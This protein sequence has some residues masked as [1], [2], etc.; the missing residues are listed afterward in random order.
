MESALN[1]VSRRLASRHARFAAIVSPLALALAGQAAAQTAE[2][3][4]AGQGAENS[5]N[6]PEIVVTAQF[7]KQRLQDT[8]LAI[9]AVNSAIMEAKHQVTISDIANSTPSL[10]IAP[11]SNGGGPAIPVLTLRGMGQSDSVGGVEPGVGVYVDDVYY[12]I[13]NGSIFELMDLDRVE[14]LR[15]PQGTLSGKNSEGGSVKLYSKE[16]SNTPEGAIEASYGSY[17]R[18]QL[19]GA[20]NIPLVDNRIM[21]RV[22]GV[23]RHERGYIKRLDYACVNPNSS[24]PIVDPA[25]VNHGCV[26]GTAGGQDL[27]AVRATLR[28]VPATG[29]EDTITVD[30]TSDH[31]GLDPA[32]L[33]F[34]GAWAGGNNFITTPRSYTSYATNIGYIG[35]P[36]QYQAFLGNNADQWGVANKLV[37][38]IEQNLSLTSISAYRHTYAHAGQSTG[39]AP[40]TPGN[41]DTEMRHSQYTQE[42]RLS[43]KVGDFAD[44]TIGGFYYRSRDLVPNHID[45]QGA[46][47]PRGAVF[48]AGGTIFYLANFRSNDP[49]HADSISAFA[50]GVF[51]LTPRLNLTGGLRYSSD[52]KSV[53]YHR[54]VVD[55][56]GSPTVCQ[57]LINSAFPP[58][59]GTVSRFSAKRLDWRLALDYRFSP[60]V[61]VYAQVA[62]GFKDGGSNPRPYFTFQAVPY[63]PESVITYE[64]G[65]KSDLFDRTLRFNT[66][67]FYSKFKDMQLIVNAC[68]N[69]TPPGL[70]PGLP[71]QQ[72]TNAG[73]SKLWGV[74]LEATAHPTDRLSID[75]TASFIDIKYTSVNAATGI[76]IGN[77]IPYLSKVKYSAGIQYDIPVFGGNPNLTGRLTPR[78]DV[79]YQSR[80]EVDPVDQGNASPTAIQ[81]G[82]V[83]ARTLVNARLSFKPDA[84]SW[85]ISAGVQN[86]FDKFYY[87]NKWDDNVGNGGYDA[88][89]G[90]VGKPRTWDVSVKYRF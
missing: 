90:Y 55:N 84:A 56:C 74:E 77:T 4:K 63:K 50:H 86:L 32:Q 17:N 8:P 28:I 30:N 36:Y 48:E 64:A 45:I 33:L 31:H 65:L 25:S 69:L 34:Q 7:Q 54:L 5:S 20:L 29:I 22:S 67:V 66:T 38:D 51:H 42:L 10:S 53:T 47:G 79:N 1:N 18:S 2:S 14:I 27:A 15:G 19:R 46:G 37:V 16:P 58:L 39:L 11:G 73:D 85:E 44:F 68:D 35:T 62:T 70:P 89:Q 83:P 59:D 24:V 13:L 76:P 75:A 78:L 9:S 41:Q 43:G 26:L 60:E 80:F 12:G 81:N 61:L 6:V 87:T 21:L 3:V 71:C 40:Y 57:Y 23:Y 49:F 52:K 88:A 82:R 72:T